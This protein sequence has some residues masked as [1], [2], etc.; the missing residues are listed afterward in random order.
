M[1]F[2]VKA[3]LHFVVVAEEASFTRA[4][5]RLG[6][7]QPWL[8]QRIRTL[9]AQ[10]GFALFERSTRRIALTDKGEAFLAVARPVAAAAEAAV[11][12][13]RVLAREAGGRLRIGAPP[14]SARIPIR[15]K[16]V[17]AFIA[18]HPG[19]ALEIDVGWTPVLLERVL[20][21]SLDGMFGLG[22]IGHEAL[23]VQA[24]G[25]LHLELLLPG[26]DPLGGGGETLAPAQLRGR[27]V[28][29][30]PRGLYPDLYDRLFGPLAAAGAILIADPAFFDRPMETAAGVES[31]IVSRLALPGAAPVAGRLTRPVEGAEA[32]PF[33]FLARADNRLPALD[34][35]SALVARV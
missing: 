19:V 7:A 22:W 32:V 12:A 17:S 26:D 2:D 35:F 27:R 11:H 3:M 13:A 33:V 23:R 29:V 21:G 14:Y 10:L 20:T 34:A 25:T 8:S 5:Q 16:L 18:A 1:H 31:E 4:A 24:L 6:I 28:G 30:F 15:T 9:E